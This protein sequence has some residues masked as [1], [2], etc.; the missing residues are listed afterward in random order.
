MPSG[1]ACLQCGNLFASPGPHKKTVCPKCGSANYIQLLSETVAAAPS[2]QEPDAAGSQDF[3][4]P[5]SSRGRPGAAESSQAT[6]NS[7][8]DTNAN[9][10]PRSFEAVP[11][12]WSPESHSEASSQSVRSQGDRSG[13]SFLKAAKSWLPAAAWWSIGLAAV[14]VVS[15]A[16]WAVGTTFVSSS[17]PPGTV[18][19][20]AGGRL[21]PRQLPEN[22]TATAVD[23]P[24]VFQPGRAEYETEGSKTATSLDEVEKAVVK[25]E[26]PLEI[27][28]VTQSGTG[29]VIN[30]RGW[31]ATNYHLIARMTKATRVKLADGTRLE[32]AGIVAKDPHR[33]LAI[34]CLQSPCPQLTALDIAFDEQ[35]AL[36]DQV[37]AF[38]HPYDADFSLSKGIV[39]RVLTTADLQDSPARHLVARLRAP[40]DLI[41]IQHDAKIS[42]GSSGGPLIDE[43]GRVLGINTF[44]HLKAEFGY[45]SHVEY[46]RRLAAT[47]SATLEP[48][49]EQRETVRTVVS[50]KQMNRLFAECAAMDWKPRT[51]EQYQLL[52]DLAK[53]MTL[54]RHLQA[55][56]KGAQ[57]RAQTALQ[58]LAKVANERFAAIRRVAWTA[59]RLEPINQLAVDQLDHVGEGILFNAVVVGADRGRGAVLMEIEPTGSPVLVRLGPLAAKFAP[60]S[61]WILIGF[62]TPEIAR[63]N[64]QGRTD[65]RP[66]RIVLTHYLLAC[67]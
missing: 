7:S 6:S 39:S 51:T 30:D 27:G 29:F 14:A 26:I 4:E 19:R 32:L 58:N 50:T 55:A 63:V 61:R 8:N 48:L 53:Q 35:P 5:V 20:Q 60:K 1:F 64:I 57:G 12:D 44:V 52:A 40:A 59:E 42:P 3:D 22:P 2:S 31:I 49:P 15:V 23:A 33:D 17:N 25:F 13:E 9:Q 16:L 46:L 21:E 36:G 45:A 37:Y 10:S 65:T 34:V 56:G 38:G 28:N 11:A 18:A 43:H 66:V 41:W 24:E 62:V 47:A 54:A 67:R